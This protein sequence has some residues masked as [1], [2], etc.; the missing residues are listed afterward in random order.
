MISPMNFNTFDDIVHNKLFAIPDYQR[1]YAWKKSSVETLLDD[2]VVLADRNGEDGDSVHFVGSIVTVDFDEDVSGATKHI[3]ESKSIKNMDKVNV[4]DGQQRLTTLSLLLMVIRD[5]AK[6]RSYTIEQDFSELIDTRKKDAGGNFIPVLNHAKENTALAYRSYLYGGQHIFDKRKIG[7]K[8]I[9]ATYEIC[10]ERVRRECDKARNSEMYLNVLRDQIVYQL[11]F[12][13]IHCT[14]ISNAFQIFES[15]NSTGLPLTPAEL[16]KSLVM[17]KYTSPD[18]GLSKW[19]E[20]VNLTSEDD[21]VAFLAQYL[22]CLKKHRVQKSEIYPS[23]KEMLKASGSVTLLLESLKAYAAVY[24]ELRSPSATLKCSGILLDFKDLSQ[25]QAYVPLM[26]AGCRFGVE[27]KD[28]EKVANAILIFCVRHN[29]CSLS[30]NKLDAIFSEALK[31]IDK[32][33]STAAD[34]EEFFKKHRPDDEAFKTAF[35]SLTFDYSAKP[36]RVAR[37]YLRRIEE[38]QRGSNQPLKISRGDLSAE[39]IIPKSADLD[40]LRGWL[41]DKIDE[42]DFDFDIDT[43]TENTVK[44]IG[45]L[46]LLFKPENS[47]AGNN[48]YADKVEVYNK[49]LIDKEGNKRGV[50]RETFKL[51]DQLLSDYPDKFDDICVAKRAKQLAELACLAWA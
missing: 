26:A 20:I 3:F 24:H 47:S 39:H 7:A 14:G 37:T 40:T 10:L 38:K 43:F 25:E 31:L 35:E 15:L 45:N 16:M 22:F 41:G 13:L 27:S 44:S 36:Q 17:S 28:F 42:K 30:T 8:N 48:S 6:E 18:V 1:D 49:E 29:V 5:V 34:I 19:D 4:I 23:Y 12:V 11:N 51:I 9:V 2:I 50:P 32:D 21:I 33:D 46:V